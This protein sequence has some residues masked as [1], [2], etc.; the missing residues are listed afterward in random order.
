M[1]LVGFHLTLAVVFRRKHN[2]ALLKE[3]ARL[4]RFLAL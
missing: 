3:C 4:F 2:I 1:F